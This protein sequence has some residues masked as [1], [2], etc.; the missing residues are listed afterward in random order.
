[1]TK[2]NCI[3]CGFSINLDDSYDD[4]E[5]QVKCFTCNALL[6]VK[7]V[8]GMVK[9]VKMAQITSS[10]EAPEYILRKKHDDNVQPQIMQY[11]ADSS[12]PH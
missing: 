4:Y 11:G 5:G 10:Q 12:I 6:E 3:C 1:M 9:G 8:E 2:I 7:L